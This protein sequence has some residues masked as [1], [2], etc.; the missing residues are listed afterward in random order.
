MEILIEQFNI[1]FDGKAKL[2][3]KNNELHITIGEKTLFLSLPDI[4]GG[5]SRGQSP[6]A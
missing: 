6:P 1:F 5:C 2:G 4:I 3:I